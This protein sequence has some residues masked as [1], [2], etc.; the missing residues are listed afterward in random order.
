LDRFYDNTRLSAFKRCPRYFYFRHVRHWTPSGTSAA[1]VFGSSWHAAMDAL[2][3]ILCSPDKFTNCEL[4]SIAD[5]A[6]DA[7][8]ANWVENGFT[9]MKDMGPDEANRLTP[10][11]PGVALEML[12]EYIEA[13]TKMLLSTDFELLA[14]EPPFA[15]PLDPDDETLF[16][17][18]RLDKVFK[19]RGKIYVGEH[20]TTTAYKKDGPFRANFLDSFSP[21]A[22]IDGYLHAVHMLYGEK[23]KAVWVDAALV[24]KTVHDGFSIIPVERKFAQIDAWLWDTRRWVDVVETEAKIYEDIGQKA[25]NLPYLPAYPKN[26]NS[27]MDYGGC[28][29]S[30]LCKMWGN[31]EGQDCPSGFVEERWSPFDELKLS[32]LGM[33]DAKD[34]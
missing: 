25:D 11:I 27:C 16:Y 18:G 32:E 28:P 17:V 21:N 13:R 30:S 26:T 33:K 12:Y 10:R 34:E 4:S 7:F 31:P 9:S 3:P 1:L 19:Y 24:H 6:I 23:A 8:D 22:Q 5:A 29:Y 15:V 14:V 2:W 20:K